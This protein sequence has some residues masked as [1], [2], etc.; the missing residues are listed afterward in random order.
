MDVIFQNCVKITLCVGI[1]SSFTAV[2]Y[3]YFYKE[4][5][6]VV[7]FYGNSV[8]INHTFDINSINVQNCDCSNCKLNII[9]GWINSAKYTLDICM[10]ILTNETISKAI[11]NAHKRGICIRIIVDEDTLKTTWEM[12]REG[13]AKKVK[14]KIYSE[15]IMHH[16]FTIVDDKK[17]ILGSLNWTKMGT[18]KNWENTFITNNRD[19][20]AEYKKEF[21]KLWNGNI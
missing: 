16:K 7:F 11:I 20:I 4:E 12:G 10:C 14:S 21:L 19:I 13:I 15:S 9:L 18:R 8:N 1:S 6:K 2:L 17:V 3:K 5:I